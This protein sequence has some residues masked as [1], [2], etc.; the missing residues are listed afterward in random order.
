RAARLSSTGKSKS[1]RL[2]SAAELAA[3]LGR[4][5]LLERLLRQADVDKSDPL[6]AA[7]IG[8]GR[9]VSQPASVKDPARV[10]A[11]LD[12]AGR[13]DS[14]NAKTLASNLVWRA[15]QRSWWS[16][17]PRG[18]RTHILVAERKLELPE[19]DPRS[20]AIAAYAEPLRN[21]GDAHA[22]L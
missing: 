5:E 16:D 2:L 13:A 17:A 12:F 1:D 14:A 20:I 8:W 22:K 18:V 11:P 3:E 4:P 6:A 9:G 15:A 19:M 21:G 10:P 7:R